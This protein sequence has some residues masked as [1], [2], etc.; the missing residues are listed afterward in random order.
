MTGLGLNTASAASK[1]A[2]PIST[3]TSVAQALSGACVSKA[4]VLQGY[5]LDGTIDRT[6]VIQ[7]IVTYCTGGA[8]AGQAGSSSRAF[9]S[10][11][12]RGL[13]RLRAALPLTRPDDY[14]G[15]ST[16]LGPGG[17]GCGNGAQADADGSSNAGSGYANFYYV[18]PN[19]GQTIDYVGTSYLFRGTGQWN[20]GMSAPASNVNFTSAAIYYTQQNAPWSL[21]TGYCGPLQIPP[22]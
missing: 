2:L 11:S 21:R 5:H 13:E 18:N 4:E 22:P 1:Q 6:S 12:W 10:S 9:T 17:N 15:G 8:P 7:A 19:D 16:P 20:V 14:R 3:P